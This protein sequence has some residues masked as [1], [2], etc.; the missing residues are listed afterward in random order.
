MFLQVRYA[1]EGYVFSLKEEGL[2]E[3]PGL[4]EYRKH[5]KNTNNY[6]SEFNYDQRYVLISLQQKRNFIG[7]VNSENKKGFVRDIPHG[8]SELIKEAI[9]NWL[10]NAYQVNW[11]SAPEGE[12]YEDDF[13]AG[14]SYAYIG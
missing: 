13:T 9:Q 12:E 4:S 1:K 8:S 10:K 5:F 14:Y 2:I 7:A 6:P 3:V 11:V